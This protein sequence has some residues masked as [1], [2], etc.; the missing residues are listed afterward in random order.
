MKSVPKMGVEKRGAPTR[1]FRQSQATLHTWSGLLLGWVLFVVFVAGTIAFWRQP[2]NRWTRPDLPRVEQPLVSLAGAQAYLRQRA[3]DATAWYITLPSAQDPGTQL[4]WI[5]RAK[6]GQAGGEDYYANS[7]LISG[8]GRPVLSGDTRGGDFFYRLH[9]DL[10]YMPVIWAR[11]IVGVAAMIM[12]VAIVTGIVT[13]KKIFADFFTLRRGR[14]QRSWLDGHAATAVLALPFHL[15]ITYTGL[16]TLVAMLMPWAAVA[17]YNDATKLNAALFPQAPAGASKGG[18]APL[19]DL[20]AIV[21]DGQRRL[22]APV[23]YIEVTSPGE[24]GARV[25]VTQIPAAQL[26]ARPPRLTYDGVSGRMLWRS[27]PS[28]GASETQGVMVGLHAGRFA[29]EALRWLYFLCGVGGSLM[30]ASGLV[31]WTVKRREKLPDPARPHLGFR[32]VERLNVAVVGGFPL[33]CVGFLWAN[34]LLPPGMA[35]RAD[36]EIGASFAIWAAAGLAALALKPRIA[37]TGLL[38][39]TGLAA[40]LLAPYDALLL[41]PGL[42]G[43]VARGDWAMAGVDLTLLALGVAFAWMARRVARHRVKVRP[44]RRIRAER[45]AAV[46]TAGEL[47]PAE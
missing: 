44:A 14:G 18:A 2:L 24:A 41:R 8:E 46:A 43:W 10:H 6:P 45:P 15:M 22:G 13:H 42:F 39:T 3:G 9:F 40:A 17:N 4:F 26:S 23:T 16:V 38:G 47:V 31:L 37:W 1:G 19:G 35:D 33:A 28:D 5:P 36:G 7:A 32:P 34:R 20:T 11:W 21:R 27:P 25:T 30:V 29:G 12:L